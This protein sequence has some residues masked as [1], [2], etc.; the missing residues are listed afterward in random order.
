MSHFAH[1]EFSFLWLYG[2][3]FSPKYDLIK[4]APCMFRL[5]AISRSPLASPVVATDT[6]PS[7]LPYASTSR[8]PPCGPSLRYLRSPSDQVHPVR[9]ARHAPRRIFWNCDSKRRPVGPPTRAPSL[10]SRKRIRRR[11]VIFVTACGV[12]EPASP[13]AQG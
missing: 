8:R 13:R 6:V 5:G 10:R 9:A 7:T 4:Q 2:T 1:P 3:T 11:R 12:L